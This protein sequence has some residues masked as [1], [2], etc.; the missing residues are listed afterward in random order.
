MKK[1]RPSPRS[2]LPV[3]RNN[4]PPQRLIDRILDT[5]HLAG[6]VPRLHP[7]V[8]HRVIQCC[9]L[10]DCAELVALAT[11]AQLMAVFDLDLW[12]AAG[13]GRDEQ[14]DAD[15]FGMWLEV[16]LE[17]GGSVAA[18]KLAA[19]DVD[20]VI[21]AIAQH[22]RV[23][24]AAAGVPRSG[25]GLECEVGGYRVVA[26]RTAVWDALVAVLIALDAEQHDCFHRVM[27][28]CRSLSNSLPEIDGLDNLLMAGEQVMFDL[29]ADREQ[30]RE[31]QGYATPAEARAF[32]EMSRQLRLTE[33][34]A[35]P[36]NAVARAYFRALDSSPATAAPTPSGSLP[37]AADPS[38]EASPDAV[39]AVVHLL[40][41]E[42]VL[43]PQP[44]A[45]LDG[46][47]D[48]PTR[49]ARM[50]A[51]MQFAHDRDAAAY[52][53]RSQELAYLANAMLAG[54]SIQGQALTLQDAS[55]AAAAVCN[56]GLENW[57]RHWVAATTGRNSS[58]VRRGGALPDDFLVGHDLVSVFQ[59]GWTV[60]HRDVCMDSARRLIATLTRFHCEDPEVQLGLDA[61]RVE[62]TKHWQGG[63]PWR[64]RDALDVIAILDM[65][66]WATLLALID[67]CPV[68]HAAIAVSQGARVR[69]VNASA[70]EFIA[71]NRQIASA[72]EFMQ[73]LPETLRR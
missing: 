62:M 2:R 24:D 12:C 25:E 45:L 69:S 32:L 73:S 55:D 42:G 56:L 26:R 19:I 41:A 21:A 53:T 63:A 54:C 67:E 47:H 51:H 8:L 71:E 22:A 46:A 44:R 43:P 7:E 17:S 30:R 6:V 61:L 72:R 3:Q 31:Q 15:R 28:G 35:P 39:A 50:W 29:G 57:P 23:F 37:A 58:T 4:P 48:Q 36:V 14:F 59:V 16:L 9:G 11:P 64:A 49:L 18:Q 5:P 13:P 70:F 34:S 27:R 65:P 68:I 40:V 10:E 66:A 20:V 1:P 52:S 33:D 60:L 38:P